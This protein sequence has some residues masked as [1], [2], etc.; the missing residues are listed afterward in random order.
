MQANP[1][2]ITLAVMRLTLQKHLPTL[3][4]VEATRIVADMMESAND[5]GI[6]FVDAQR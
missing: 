3:S 2:V 6:I 5:I 4:K 1:N